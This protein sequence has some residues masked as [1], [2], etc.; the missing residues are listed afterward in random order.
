MTHGAEFIPYRNVYGSELRQYNREMHEI[1]VAAGAVQDSIDVARYERLLR[2]VLLWQ[3][4]HGRRLS[5]AEVEQA[6]QEAL[7]G[8]GVRDG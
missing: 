8:L 5:T 1:M 3:D 4:E 2:A 7:R 6:R